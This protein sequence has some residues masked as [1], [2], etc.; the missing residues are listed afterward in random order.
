MHYCW[1]VDFLYIFVK[2]LS[3]KQQFLAVSD[4]SGVLHVL[5]IRRTLSHPSSNE[6]SNSFHLFLWHIILKTAKYK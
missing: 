1:N 4:D 3:A 6:V 5:E 2:Y